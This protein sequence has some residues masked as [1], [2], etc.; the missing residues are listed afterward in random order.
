LAH[1]RQEEDLVN[2]YEGQMGDQ[3][4][5]FEEENKA[6]KKKYG[7]KLQVA[8][9]RLHKSE[10][11]L[12]LKDAVLAVVERVGAQQAATAVP[13]GSKS[14]KFA[15][16][17][18]PTSPRPERQPS[19]RKE[20]PRPAPAATADPAEHAA[21]LAKVQE[22]EDQI[23]QQRQEF[24]G[25]LARIQ[26]SK[27]SPRGQAGDAPPAAGVAAPP[28]LTPEQSAQTAELA[29][30]RAQE[31]SLLGQ[32]KQTAAELQPAVGELER[33]NEEK[34]ACKND[35]KEWTRAFLEANGREPNVQVCLLLCVATYLITLIFRFVSIVGQ[36]DREGQVPKV[37]DPE[38]PSQR[39]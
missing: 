31:A 26:S 21:L 38:R 30:L 24:E 6:L 17:E 25:E 23:S 35:I 10:V 34:E 3:R 27:V 8:S 22:L 1:N 15:S 4:R 29:Q 39:P 14:V 5:Q 33:L 16:A 36:S 12:C 7:M 20:S 18:Q 11:Q 9:D 37:Q 2:R 13:V 28:S 19:P 32:Q